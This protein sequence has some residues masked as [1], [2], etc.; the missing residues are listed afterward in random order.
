MNIKTTKEDILPGLNIIGGV[1]ERRQTLPILGN[2]LFQVESD[3]AMLTATDLE[4][5]IS[6]NVDVRS[7]GIHDSGKKVHRHMQGITRRLRH[8]YRCGK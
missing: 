8:Q 7:R 2:I 5:E 3:K 6:V 4:M 1:V